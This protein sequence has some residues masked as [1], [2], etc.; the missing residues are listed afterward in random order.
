MGSSPHARGTPEWDTQSDT[1]SGI[2]PACAGNT[3]S[4]L[5][6][7][8]PRWDHPRMRGEHRSDTLVRSSVLGSSPHARGTQSTRY[9]PACRPGIIPACAGNTFTLGHSGLR[10][11]DHPRMRGE[12]ATYTPGAWC[13][14][15]SS[16]HARGT[17]SIQAATQQTRGIIP[18]CAGNTG[19]SRPRVRACRDH[20]RMRGEHVQAGALCHVVEGSSPHARGT[21]RAGHGGRGRQGI[22]P[23][24]AGNTL[25]FKNLKGETGDH[26]RMRGE[27]RP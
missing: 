25:D 15:G 8:L 26:P 2:I 19:M 27:H 24:C 17:Q 14:P 11:G 20:P 4:R 16:P 21:L 6:S 3:P 10:D 18:A 1:E 5:A 23:A 22:I 12:H 9:D 7:P 13:P